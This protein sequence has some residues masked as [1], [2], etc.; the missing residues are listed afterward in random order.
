MRLAAFLLLAPAVYAAQG[1]DHGAWDRVV[2]RHVRA[3]GEV[4]SAALRADRRDLDAYLERIAE[5]SPEN[6]PDLFP[7]EAS[8]IAYWI[9]AYNALTVDGVLRD[10]PFPGVRRV[11]RFFERRIYTVGG[12]LTS[13]DGIEHETLRKK[14]DEPRIHFALVCA[15]VS[16]PRLAP[17]AFDHGKLDEQLEARARLFVSE[18]RNVDVDGRTVTLSRIFDWFGGDFKSA[19]GVLRFVRERSNV[20]LPE[21]PKLKYFD[22]DWSL[23]EPGSRARSKNPLERET[24]R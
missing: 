11:K 21:R 9:N 16:C 8:R 15:S 20:E 7:D 13:L 2:D 23:N 14:F 1:F 17:F 6:Q 18:R 10:D 4:D 22:Y 5:T 19:G 12:R 24:A 3:I